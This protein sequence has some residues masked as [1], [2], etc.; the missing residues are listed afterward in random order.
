VQY[1]DHC[2]GVLSECVVLVLQQAGGE[3]RTRDRGGAHFPVYHL[4]VGVRYQWMKGMN[5]DELN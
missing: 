1:Y 5:H 3:G 4:G 2:G